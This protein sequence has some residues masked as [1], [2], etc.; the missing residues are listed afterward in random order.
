MIFA[1]GVHARADN[2]IYLWEPPQL[3]V[4]CLSPANRKRP[5]D[6]LLKDYGSI[7]V[8]EVWLP[9]PERSLCE[10]R[11]G[12]QAIRHSEGIVNF[13]DAADAPLAILWRAFRGE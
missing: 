13:R 4:E 1:A 3:I 12:G 6:E 11:R 10:V 5:A 2:P 8:P 9:K 7:G